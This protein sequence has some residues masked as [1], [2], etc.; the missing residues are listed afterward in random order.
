MLVVVDGTGI[1]QFEYDVWFLSHQVLNLSPA[2]LSP[3]G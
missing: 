3:V 2:V 1:W